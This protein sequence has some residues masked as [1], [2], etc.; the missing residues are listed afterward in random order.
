MKC[1]TKRRQTKKG[2]G[3]RRRKMRMR[4]GGFLGMENWHIFQNWGNWFG[5]KSAEPEEKPASEEELASVEEPETGE[6]A[7]EKPASEKPASNPSS[8]TGGRKKRTKNRRHKKNKAKKSMKR[9]H[10]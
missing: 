8:G 9:R 3:T 10:R 2:R 6:P 7:S 4:G 5:S 1:H